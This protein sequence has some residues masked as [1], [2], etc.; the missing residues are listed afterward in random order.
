MTLLGGTVISVKK[1]HDVT[2][3][4]IPVEMTAEWTP[5][6]AYPGPQVT[7]TATQPTETPAPIPY[8]GVKD[9]PY[10]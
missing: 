6:S 4:P 10:P 7:E 3:T 8:P 9:E 2:L 5:T 1:L